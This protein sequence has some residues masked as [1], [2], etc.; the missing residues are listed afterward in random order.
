MLRLLTIEFHKLRYNKASK[1]LSII[2]FGLLTSI[3]L[4]AAI[5]FEFGDFK[6]HLA[7]AG[8]F[9]FPYIWHFNTFIAAILKFFLLLV[10][11]SMMSNEYSYK[12][13]KQNLIDGLSKKEFILSKFYTVI[14]FALISTLFVFVVSLILGLVYSDFDEF[15]I[16]VSDLDYLLAFFV[17]LVGFFSFGLFLGILVKRSAFAVGAMFVWL[18]IESMF[19]GYLY[20]QFQSAENTGEK[21]DSIM[22]F[23][24]LEAMSNLIK[25]PFSRLGAVRSAANTMGEMFTKSYD[26]EV[27]NVLIVSAWTFIFI[28]LSYK[29]LLKRDL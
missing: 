4:I 8:I 22:Q 16:I 18:I 17:K 5:K 25:E 19:K 11:V 7:D 29:L 10:I 20:W 15:S 26:V 27:I 24:P 13:L 14:A 21:V 3:A 23:L 12:T 9:N 6:L 1:V 2:Y 28:Y